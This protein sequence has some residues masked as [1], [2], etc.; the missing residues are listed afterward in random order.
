MSYFAA[1]G[2]A[3]DGICN[4]LQAFRR[5]MYGSR[6]AWIIFSES[7]PSKIFGDAYKFKGTLKCSSDEIG[8]AADRCILTTKLDIRQ[9]NHQ[10][11]SG[12]VSLR[13]LQPTATM[14]LRRNEFYCG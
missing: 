13:K 9:D 5:K 14:N 4:S 10:T 2:N 7:S 6:Y 3:Y 11:I 8:Q 12:M 1:Q